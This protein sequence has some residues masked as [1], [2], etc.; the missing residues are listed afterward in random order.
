MKLK[1][2]VFAVALLA[3]G[4]LIASAVAIMLKLSRS[5]RRIIKRNW[6]KL[7]LRFPTRPMKLRLKRSLGIQMA[8]FAIAPPARSDMK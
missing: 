4:S 3:T 7:K 8:G 2:S 5:R 1:L 6:M